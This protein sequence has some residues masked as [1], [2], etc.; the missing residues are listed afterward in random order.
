MLDRILLY[1]AVVVILILLIS[2]F[3]VYSATHPKR[4]L[5][6]MTPDDMGL[7]YEEV[8]F[9]TEDNLTLRGW[10]IG[11]RTDKTIVVLHGYPFNRANILAFAK[12]LHPV[13]QVMVFDFRGMGESEG[14]LATGG[15]KEQK[16]LQAA[17]KYLR[18][19]KDVGAIG[20][21]GFSYGAS[22]A[23]MTED[24]DVKAIVADSGFA[25]LDDVVERM[26]P[27]WVFKW[28]FVWSSKV[29]AKWFYGIDTSKVTPVESVK[30]V[31]VPVLFIHGTA[32]SQVSYRDSEELFEAANEPKEMWLIE[33]ADHGAI[34]QAKRKEY[35]QRVRDFLFRHMK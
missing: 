33:G 25:R 29:M 35:E 26:Y 28:P 4:A 12:F 8:T 23:L 16:D 2:F 5:L 10:F 6:D 13:F 24:V 27:Y 18:S 30:N 34:P 21:Y 20:V 14:K 19:R 22:V 15:L 3:G 31:T 32:D 11:S 9:E 7:G 1:I 17:V